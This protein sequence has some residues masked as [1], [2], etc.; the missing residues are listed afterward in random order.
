MADRPT[1]STTL[2]SRARYRL[3]WALWRRA[4]VR[5]AKADFADCWPFRES[6]GKGAREW[7]TANEAALRWWFHYGAT[8]PEAYQAVSEENSHG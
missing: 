8:P 3:R 6:V 2:I 1:P 7:V 5:E 4:V